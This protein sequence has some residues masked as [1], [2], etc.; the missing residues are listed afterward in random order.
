MRQVV[1]VQNLTGVSCLG[2]SCFLVQVL[3]NSIEI[4]PC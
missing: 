2:A 1:L 3:C 4:L